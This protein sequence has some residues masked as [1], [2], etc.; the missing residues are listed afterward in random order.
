MSW[1]SI[2]I[3]PPP[4][5]IFLQIEPKEHNLLVT[6][7]P[8]TPSPL[9]EYSAQVIFEEFGFASCCKR[10]AA[11]LSAYKYCHEKGGGASWWCWW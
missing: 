6:E 11:S 4:I 5:S 7:P 2:L 3:P 10:P 9:P 8:F 1:G